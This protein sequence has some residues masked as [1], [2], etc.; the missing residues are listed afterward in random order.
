MNINK[1]KTLQ[2]TIPIIS[3]QIF[4][5]E[6]SLN[7]E[8]KNLLLVLN[9]LKKHINTQFSL[10]TCVSGVDLLFTNYRFCVSY[11]LLSLVNNSRIRVKSFVNESTYLDSSC[12]VY[13]NANWWEREVWDMYGIY[14]QN[15]PDLRRILTDYGFEGY[16]LRKDFPLSGYVEVSYDS[17]KKRVVVEPLELAQEFRLFSYETPWT[18]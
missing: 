17:S 15:H 3:Y 11:D 1:Y 8:S 18:K 10:L 6:I 13:K 7:V 14:F 4:N 5:D 2:K 9:Y 12:S 16:P